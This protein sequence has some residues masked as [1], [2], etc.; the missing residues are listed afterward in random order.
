[1]L[2]YTNSPG[3]EAN[4]RFPAFRAALRDNGFELFADDTGTITIERQTGSRHVTL[5]YAL[6]YRPQ[7]QTL[8]LRIN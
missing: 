2:L 7:Q 8:R 4:R 3:N 1:M 5:R 6:F